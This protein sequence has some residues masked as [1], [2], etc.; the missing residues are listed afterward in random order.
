MTEANTAPI[1]GVGPLTT[2]INNARGTE[3]TSAMIARLSVLSHA[4]AS[5]PF[6]VARAALQKKVPWLPGPAE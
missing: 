1:H 3:H 5:L 6:M 2:T 4:V